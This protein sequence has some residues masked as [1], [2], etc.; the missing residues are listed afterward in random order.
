MQ[1]QKYITLVEKGM[2]IRVTFIDF[3]FQVM[4][5]RILTV[6]SSQI[7]QCKS[8][9]VK[10]CKISAYGLESII[11]GG[12]KS[13]VKQMHQNIFGCFKR[14]VLTACF[15]IKLFCENKINLSP[16]LR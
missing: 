5:P 8:G 4:H 1:K 13:S 2:R 14:L 11:G 7:H 15:D 6:V 12:R 9:W 10:V 3:F 16:D